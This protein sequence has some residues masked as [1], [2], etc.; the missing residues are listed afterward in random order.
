M[1]Y[2]PLY[3]TIFDFELILINENLLVLWA[4]LMTFNDQ[5]LFTNNLESQSF[6]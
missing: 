3:D 2:S 1:D 4:S 5:N 6:L